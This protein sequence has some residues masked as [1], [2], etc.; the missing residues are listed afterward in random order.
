VFGT[1]DH[2]GLV[3]RD[4][5]AS[6]EAAREVFGLE[7]ARMAPLAD[8]AID[9]A[10]LGEGRGTLEIFTFTDPE[11]LEPRLAGADQRLDH[12]A[13]RVA[14]LDA[15]AAALRAAGARFVTPDR[16]RELSAPLELGG[17]RNLWTL[18]DTTGGLALQLI[19]PPP[20]Q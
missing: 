16:R 11:V 15:L 2:I 7:L 19:Q 18:P 4:L 13:L 20:G 8:Y 17:W 12:V 14:D 9:A 5:D 3:V 1:L 10:F 6:V